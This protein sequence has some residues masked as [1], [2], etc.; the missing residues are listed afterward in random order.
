[1]GRLGVPANMLLNAFTFPGIGIQ[2]QVTS[3]DVNEWFIA[4]D[5]QLSAAAMHIYIA[6]EHFDADLRLIDANKNRVPVSLD[7]FDLIY[8]GGRIYF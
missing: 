8:S 4:L 5:Q 7:D 6:Y 1:V 2:T 3:S